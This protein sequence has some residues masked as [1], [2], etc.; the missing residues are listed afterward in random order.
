M[1]EF[2]ILPAPP[3]HH[4]LTSTHTCFI[5]STSWGPNNALDGG[6]TTSTRQGLV[7]SVGDINYSDFVFVQYMLDK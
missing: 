4:N 6:I 2:I 5:C 3:G 1:P 7:S